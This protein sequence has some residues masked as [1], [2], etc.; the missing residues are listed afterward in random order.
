MSVFVMEAMG[1]T[2][3]ASAGF[4]RAVLGVFPRSFPGVLK[5]SANFLL[6]ISTY[7]SSLWHLDCGV[8]LVFVE[9]AG[10]VFIE[11]VQLIPCGVGELLNLILCYLKRSRTLV[12]N[13]RARADLETRS[14]H[15]HGE[16]A[17][18]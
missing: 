9:Y 18:V 7:S 12:C 17:S 8:R 13:P 2:T 5:A 14:S 4:L 11:P 1:L 10:H 3:R 15:R 6:E 16:R